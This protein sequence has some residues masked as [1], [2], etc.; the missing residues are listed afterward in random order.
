[1]ENGH[2]LNHHAD[3]KLVC[4]SRERSVVLETECKCGSAVS[5]FSDHI[6]NDIS[7]RFLHVNANRINS[8]PSLKTCMKNERMSVE[9]CEFAKACSRLKR[10]SRRRTWHTEAAP[11][12]GRHPRSA[13]KRS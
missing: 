4:G 12:D 11:D 10:K 5:S 7:M 9:I 6:I 13:T 3:R 1:M 8:K 2:P